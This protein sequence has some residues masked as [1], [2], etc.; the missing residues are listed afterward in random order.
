M[1]GLLAPFQ[2]MI[3]HRGVESDAIHQPDSDETR[4]AIDDLL[5][6]EM[7]FMPDILQSGP[8]LSG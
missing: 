4:N 3:S 8:M 6:F 5:G 2:L 7:T 1:K